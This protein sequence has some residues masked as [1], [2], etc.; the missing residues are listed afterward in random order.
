MQLMTQLMNVAMNG[1]LG[2]WEPFVQGICAREKLPPFDKLSIDCIQEEARIESRNGN[3]RGSDDENLALATHARKGR[4][5][6]SLGRE[7]SPKQWKKK[8]LSKVKCFVCHKLGHYASQCPQQKKGRWKQQ[9]SSTEV[10]EVADKFLREFLLVFALFG[11]ICSSGTWLVDSG[12]ARHMTRSLQSLTSLSEEDSRLQVELGDNAK[13]PVKGVGTASFQLESG[14]L[15]K[16]S[17][18]L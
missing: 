6:G 13:Y 8:D 2:S 11:T 18:V 7:A 5:N 16:M 15:L 3:Q 14:K 17:D 12:A 9:A 1:F 4:G 10:D